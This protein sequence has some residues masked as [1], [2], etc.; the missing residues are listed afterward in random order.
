MSA[1]GFLQGL[2]F[3]QL[4]HIQPSRYHIHE[5]VT[6]AGDTLSRQAIDKHFTWRTIAFLE[7]ILGE[8]LCLQVED[9]PSQQGLLNHFNGV[10]IVDGTR[11]T[12]GEKLLTRLNLQTGLVTF[13]R[14]GVDVHDNAV[15]LA[16]EPLPAGSLR[17]A[18]LGFFDLDHF[19]QDNE[20]D[21]YWISRYKTGTYLLSP[22]TQHPI[23]LL[24]QLQQ[25]DCL[26]MPVLIGKDKQVPAYLVAHRVTDD[27]V[28]QRRDNHKR[29][30]Q[31]KKQA[32]S[33]SY[34]AL[35][36]W[37]IYLTNI[38]ALTPSAIQALAQMRWQIET[39]FKLWKSDMGLDLPQSQDPI[40]QSCLFLAKLIA[41]WVA[42]ALMSVAPQVNRSWTR[43]LRVVRQHALHAIF[44]LTLRKTWLAFLEQLGFYLDQ[45]ISMDKRKKRPL[46]FQALFK[47]P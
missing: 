27:V 30:N 32:I 46:S 11:L 15:E 3:S 24:T 28:Q 35:S 8:L 20:D 23:D 17:L 41:I 22:E 9:I 18:D 6:Y 33:N 37:T 5:F 39:V 40:R 38:P 7:A 45:L 34:L 31:R 13:E 43:A 12:C 26:Y 21:I 44:A 16:H 4:S 1:E 36:G 42:H 10:Y 19:Q 29:R 14:V 2:V 25:H 47:Y